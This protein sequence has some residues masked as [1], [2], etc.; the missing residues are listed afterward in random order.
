MTSLYDRVNSSDEGSRALAGARLR[1][2]VLKVLHRA[3]EQSGLNQ[4]Q[5]A[6]K[7]GVR[8]SAVNQVFRGDGNVRVT[9]IAEYLHE[10]GMELSV[11]PVPGTHREA[12][13]RES[14]DR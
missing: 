4:T 11:H 7:L 10:M 1:Y 2:E 14:R 13:T 8:K 6:R 3:L 12:A 9:T 5:L